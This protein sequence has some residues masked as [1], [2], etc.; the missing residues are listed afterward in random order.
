MT[1]SYVTIS[2]LTTNFFPGSPAAPGTLRRVLGPIY[3]R[4]YSDEMWYTFQRDLRLPVPM[5]NLV[6]LHRGVVILLKI[7]E[8]SGDTQ[9]L[10]PGK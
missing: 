10:H 6:P 5:Q 1:T 3:H 2:L 4:P 7:K 8:M 9:S